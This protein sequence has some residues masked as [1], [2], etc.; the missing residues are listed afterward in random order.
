MHWVWATEHHP[1]KEA[2]D[3]HRM[4]LAGKEKPVSLINTIPFVIS[5]DDRIIWKK[6]ASWKGRSPKSS[7]QMEN[8]II[9][10]PIFV[11]ASKPS[12]MQ[13]SKRL[14]CLEAL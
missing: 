2:R 6:G 8:S 5:R 13:L 3:I 14:D 4:N 12:M 1:P 9:Y 11:I 10:P 7:M